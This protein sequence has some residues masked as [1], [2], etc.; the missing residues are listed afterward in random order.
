MVMLD[1]KIGGRVMAAVNEGQVLV[2]PKILA[3]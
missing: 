3:T 1:L 2:R